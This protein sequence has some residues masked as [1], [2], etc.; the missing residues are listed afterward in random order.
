M[1]GFRALDSII[2]G[3]DMGVN[4]FEWFSRRFKHIESVET[5]SGTEDGS[6]FARCYEWRL[7]INDGEVKERY[8]TG[9]EFSLDFPM[10][11][12]DFVGVKN[13]YGYT[14]VVDCIASSKSGDC[15]L[16]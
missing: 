13:N 9:T 3:P 6:F 5:K 16:A 4:K 7:N 15:E 14:H 11:H 2:P 10:V 1:R 8:L 12:G